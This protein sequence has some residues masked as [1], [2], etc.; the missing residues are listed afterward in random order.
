MTDSSD[1]QKHLTTSLLTLLSHSHTSTSSLLAYV[2]SSPGV[3]LS[4]RRAVR[5]AAFEGPVSSSHEANGSVVDDDPAHHGWAAYVSSLEDFR[6]DLKQI[7]LLE[8]EMSRVKRD[9]EILVSRLIKTT[10]SRPTK[11]DIKAM[12]DTLAVR[13]G[14]VMSSQSSIYSHN[15]DSSVTH[16]ETKRANKLAEAQAELLGCEEHLRGLEVRVEAERNKVMYRGLEERFRA[17]EAVGQMWINQAR[18]GLGDLDKLPDLPPNA[19]ELDS[20]GSIAPSQSAS[21]VGHDDGGATPT[22]QKRTMGRHMLSRR[23][24]ESVTDSIAEEAEGGSSDDE[25]HG[26]LVMHENRPTPIDTSSRA[27]HA[28]AK[29]SPLRTSR[30]PIASQ[31]VPNRR[32]TSDVGAMAPYTPSRSKL[33]R[34]MSDE[35]LHQ[36]EREDSD[37]SSIGSHRPRHKKGG[38]FKSL[39]N[40]F[41]GPKHHDHERPSPKSKGGWQTRTDSRIKSGPVRR[42]SDSSSD[43][44]DLDNLLAVSNVN[45]EFGGWSV[46]DAGRETVTAP[47]PGMKRSAS[48]RSRSTVATQS[49]VTARR[50]FSPTIPPPSTLPSVSRSNTVKS[51][52]TVKAPKSATGGEKTRQNGA[53]ARSKSARSSRP[54]DNIMSIVGAPPPSM[55]DVPKAPTSQPQMSLPKAPGSSLLPTSSGVQRSSS[56][57]LPSQMP[58]RSSHDEL[59]PS[60]SVS[61]SNSM[62]VNKTAKPKANGAA[63]K[64]TQK[65]KSEVG[66]TTTK[67]VSKAK[68][69][70]GKSPA[71]Q[72][73][74][75]EPPPRPVSPL[76][77]SKMRSPPLKSALRPTSPVPPA[78]QLPAPVI[79]TLHSVTAPGPVQLPPDPQPEPEQPEASR[80]S[81]NTR[82]SY[83]STGDETSIY[84]SAN[85]AGGGDD[86]SDFSEDNTELGDTGYTVVD[87]DRVYRRAEV[88]AAAT[89][90]P[91][92]EPSQKPRP[93][94]NAST[95]MAA[96][97]SLPPVPQAP[98]PVSQDDDGK[99]V[100]R[101]SVRM[102]LPPETPTSPAVQDERGR[103]L[104]RE[105]AFADAAVASSK[106]EDSPEPARI[107]EQWD[108]RIGRVRDDS[109]DDERGGLTEEY[110]RAR[111]GLIRQ[112]GGFDKLLEKRNKKDKEKKSLSRSGSTKSKGSLMSRSSRR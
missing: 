46:A 81:M 91:P 87:N 85:E 22:P 108:T 54:A 53:I 14:T 71:R 27:N 30:S 103:E 4:V 99:I 41:K 89:G 28:P 62:R 25:P 70:V 57:I 56:M 76:P 82:P 18:R 39:K 106:R 34:T 94:S 58:P 31:T 2:T 23:G 20:N 32:A 83:A 86:D 92:P 47:R 50:A 38:F 33:R 110:S 88:D 52:G 19:F 29:S 109:S 96:Q 16:R 43:E 107:H 13:D 63:V 12:A 48:A 44:D 65:A 104:E 17:M 69:D 72:Q 36:N 61:R 42:R 111:K 60:D 73:G 105:K 67:P 40:F 59:R 10:K 24:P 112:S 3:L 8:E 102:N 5:F 55:P 21:Q 77:P 97:R 35:R 51:T 9:R 66:N 84:E 93:V 45:P 101:K 74:T 78:T 68:S 7:H 1:S 26:T 6:R 100:R 95:I 98:G 11:S 37:A 80:P 79:T 15:S 49:T 64:T 75:T 90:A